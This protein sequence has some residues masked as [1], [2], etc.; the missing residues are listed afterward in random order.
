MHLL[1]IFYNQPSIASQVLH[2]TLSGF[3]PH[4][5]AILFSKAEHQQHNQVII[6][7]ATTLNI[8]ML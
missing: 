8:I 4:P 3:L 7:I 5:S 2:P 6:D 1:I